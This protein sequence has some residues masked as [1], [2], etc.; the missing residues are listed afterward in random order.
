MEDGELVLVQVFRRFN[1]IIG[2]LSKQN[3]P[4]IKGVN[5]FKNATVC[6]ILIMFIKTDTP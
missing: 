4:D 6:F 1:R 5:S 2:R 3:A